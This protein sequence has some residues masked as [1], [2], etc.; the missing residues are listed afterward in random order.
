MNSKKEKKKKKKEN[1][2]VFDF[3][4]VTILMIAFVY[5]RQKV[6]RVSDKAPKRIKG[7]ALVAANHIG[8]LDPVLIHCVFWD[9]RMW[10]LATKDLYASKAKRR[11]FEAAHCI[12]VDKENFSMGSL[13]AACDRLK[14]DKVVMI[15]PEGHVNFEAEKLDSY[16]SGAILMA[17]L[18]KKPIIPVYIAPPKRWYNRRVVVVGE[19]IDVNALCGKIPTMDEMEKASA[20]MREKEM[21]LKE[22]YENYENRRKKK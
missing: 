2:F 7:G 11:F 15:F 9:R 18:S 4:K 3:I 8:F 22:Y 1:N 21:Q 19:P 13:H 5:F 6:L 16:K 20:Y 12:I 17:H 14:D 10:C